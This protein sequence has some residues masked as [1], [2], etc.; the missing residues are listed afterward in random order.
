MKL[1]IHFSLP[2]NLPIDMIMIYNTCITIIIH[3]MCN[4]FIS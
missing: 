1:N 4:A 2:D 3:K